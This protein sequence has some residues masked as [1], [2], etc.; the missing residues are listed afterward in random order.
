[1]MT[2][3]YLELSKIEQEVICKELHARIAMAFTL[4]FDLQLRI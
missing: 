4:D 1:M 2:M 3:K